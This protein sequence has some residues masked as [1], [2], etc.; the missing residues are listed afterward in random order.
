M[1]KN[2]IVYKASIA[3]ELLRKGYTIN[4]IKPNREQPLASIFIFKNE[5]GLE[6]ELQRFI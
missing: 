2:W 4:D 5:T 1:R 3:R 6:E